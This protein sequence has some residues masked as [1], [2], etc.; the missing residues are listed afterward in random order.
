MT[1]PHLRAPRR[2]PCLTGGAA[3]SG[4]GP[5][6]EPAAQRTGDR[7]VGSGADSARR[8]TGGTCSRTISSA[9]SC[10]GSMEGGE[11]TGSGRPHSGSSG[12][13]G[14]SPPARGPARR[15][16]HAGRGSAAE[17]GPREPDSSPAR[18]GTQDS[19]PSRHLVPSLGA[20]ASELQHWGDVRVD[21]DS[22]A[23]DLKLRYIIDSRSPFGGITRNQN[24]RHFILIINTD[25][26]SQQSSSVTL[27]GHFNS[28]LLQA[29]S[30]TQ[31]E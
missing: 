18:P 28:R 30:I 8:G 12:E 19:A 2:R 4:L 15:R 13:V 24:S 27:Y 31:S 23:L 10:R 6:R 9:T 26:V 5:S 29:M 22:D 7:K 25:E 17:G 14:A 1:G 16:P 11:A 21:V 3:D 20:P